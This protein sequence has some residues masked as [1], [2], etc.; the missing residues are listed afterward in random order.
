MLMKRNDL[1]SVRNSNVNTKYIKS[2]NDKLS[3]ERKQRKEFRLLLKHLPKHAKGCYNKD[4]KQRY[5]CLIKIRRLVSFHGYAMEPIQPVINTGVVKQLINI[6]HHNSTPLLQFEALWILTNLACGNT[7]QTKIL[8]KYEIISSLKRVLKSN[9]T[10]NEIKSQA[11]W[12]LG[13]IAGDCSYLRSVLFVKYDMF[14]GVL[15]PILT[16][17]SLRKCIKTGKPPK[18]KHELDLLKESSWCLSNFCR[19][20]SKKLFYE[21]RE[22]IVNIFNYLLKSKNRYV[23][24]NVCWAISY[25]VENRNDNRLKVIVDTIFDNG[26]I[27]KLLNLLTI[28][29]DDKGNNCLFHAPLRVIGDIV[30]R[31]KNN[32]N[33]WT[34]QLIDLNVF[35]KFQYILTNEKNRKSKTYKSK[36]KHICWMISNMV[37]NKYQYDKIIDELN[38]NELIV[39]IMKMFKYSSF[40]IRIE[41]AYI[42]MNIISNCNSLQE[43]DHIHKS[44]TI[45]PALFKLFRYYGNSKFSNKFGIAI[46]ETIQHLLSLGQQYNNYKHLY[47][48]LKCSGIEQLESLQNAQNSKDD[49]NDDNDKIFQEKIKKIIEF[50]RY[51]QEERL[52]LVKCS[53]KNCKI[54]KYVNGEIDGTESCLSSESCASSESSF[55][56]IRKHKFYRCKKCWIAVYCSRKCQKY[57]WKNGHKNNCKNV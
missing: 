48:A 24:N 55:T 2:H 52:L 56:R 19:K 10:N 21:N 17:D 3:A 9:Q 22:A 51:Q 45:I 40:T 30:A 25:F 34:L 42:I 46:L 5:Q 53:R 33:K 23:L 32:T 57:H 12:C 20:G 44:S 29:D 41:A 26:L 38:K 6:L 35:N 7:I 8:V 31:E 11:M 37:A 4:Y 15:V 47:H 1:I 18:D 43:V 50:L 28:K 14:Y 39:H 13:N 27:F 16:S 49:K 36:R 54:T